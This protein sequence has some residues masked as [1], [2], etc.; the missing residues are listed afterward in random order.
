M[1]LDSF[2]T[3]DLFGNLTPEERLKVQVLAASR[4]SDLPKFFN[5]ATQS[6]GEDPE[7]SITKEF[8]AFLILQALQNP[9]RLSTAMTWFNEA[10]TL[11]LARKDRDNLLELAYSNEKADALAKLQEIRTRADRFNVFRSSFTQIE[12]G[13]DD[14][15]A[16]Y[17]A[18]RFSS[19]PEIGLIFRD[20]QAAMGELS[21][22][23]KRAE[24]RVVSNEVLDLERKSRDK[25]ADSVS[26]IA[27]EKIAEEL[28]SWRNAISEIQ[29]RVTGVV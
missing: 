27:D 12:V 5:A 13:P 8:E 14:E 15:P 3:T 10:A 6:I 25:T 9:D 26:G 11:Q 17:P 23:Q 2:V 19:V 1:P 16:D 29:A 18:A 20:S 7:E 22:D 21:S 28:L 24:Y 4:S